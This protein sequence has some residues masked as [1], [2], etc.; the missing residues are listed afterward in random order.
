M[1]VGLLGLKLPDELRLIGLPL[2]LCLSTGLHV[3]CATELSGP[4]PMVPIGL[5]VL[6][7]WGL[8][9]LW[10]IWLCDLPKWLCVYVGPKQITVCHSES[11]S[12]IQLALVSS[13]HHK[14]ILSLKHTICPKC[15]KTNTRNFHS[16]L[17]HTTMYNTI[18]KIIVII[19]NKLSV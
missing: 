18:K 5:G 7:P 19:L 14:T 6:W 2:K 15:Y 17:C 9:V 10:L 8:P 12:Y 11:L 4:W 16:I 3:L 1:H 13:K